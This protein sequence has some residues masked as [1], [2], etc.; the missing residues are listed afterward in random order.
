M[1][2]KTLSHVSYYWFFDQFLNIIR[3]QIK[4]EM[5]FFSCI[6]PSLWFTIEY[7]RNFDF[8][9]QNLAKWCQSW[10]KITFQFGEI[11]WKGSRVW[12]IWILIRTRW[13]CEHIKCWKNIYLFIFIIGYFNP[14]IRYF[15][16]FLKI[17]ISCWKN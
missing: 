10:L 6:H 2:G 7:S 9:K 3:S 1:V 4:I 5:I 8:L 16:N 12:R 15:C 11:N 14:F 17:K 13:S